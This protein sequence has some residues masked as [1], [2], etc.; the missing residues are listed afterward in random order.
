[1]LLMESCQPLMPS[2]ALAGCRGCIL[3]TG[4]MYG[5]PSLQL[6]PL[7]LRCPLTDLNHFISYGKYCHKV[8]KKKPSGI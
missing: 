3:V 7:H 8:A 5:H 2:V 6:Q 1:M 4:H